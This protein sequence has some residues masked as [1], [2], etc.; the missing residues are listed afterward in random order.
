MPTGI[1]GSR[2]G[3]KLGM[4]TSASGLCSTSSAS[5]ASDVG[6]PL[7]MGPLSMYSIQ[8]LWRSLAHVFSGAGTERF[9]LVDARAIEYC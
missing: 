8:S 4:A 5:M 9:G 3:P 2:H 7:L 6:V 1:D